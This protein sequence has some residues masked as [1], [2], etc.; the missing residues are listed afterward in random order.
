MAELA[1]NGLNYST[2]TLVQK[3]SSSQTPECKQLFVY[4]QKLSLNFLSSD[5]F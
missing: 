3:P 1:I 4:K 2:G 5:R